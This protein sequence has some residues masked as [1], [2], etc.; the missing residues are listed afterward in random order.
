M[1]ILPQR[2]QPNWNC[3]RC[4]TPRYFH[5]Q[6]I[7]RRWLRKVKFTCFDIEECISILE[8]LEGALERKYDRWHNL[9]DR[10]HFV[11]DEKKGCIWLNGRLIG[12]FY[13]SQKLTEHQ[14]S[15][16]KRL[17]RIAG[18]IERLEQNSA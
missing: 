11:C 1:T 16:I 12:G 8:L 4:T 6:S 5:A 13:S 14:V 2:S 3:P 7:A 9:G 18:K 17:C 10:R 15:Y